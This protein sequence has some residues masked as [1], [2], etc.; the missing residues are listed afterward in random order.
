MEQHKQKSSIILKYAKRR[1]DGG[2]E[3]ETI[4]SIERQQVVSYLNKLHKENRAQE[5]AKIETQAAE[6]APTVEPQVETPVSGQPSASTR[7]SR[8]L[9]ALVVGPV[10]VCIGLVGLMTAGLA[11]FTFKRVNN[12][13]ML[14]QSKTLLNDCWGTFRKG[15][16]DTLTTPFRVV[17]AAISA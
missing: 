4:R 6:P 9:H 8:V 7:K 13:P 12:E 10:Q 3:I 11:L 5:A 15:L 16:A 2:P 14:K 17:K 1:Y